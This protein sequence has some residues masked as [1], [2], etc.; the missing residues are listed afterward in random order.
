MSP[1]GQACRPKSERVPFLFGGAQRRPLRSAR[2]PTNAAESWQFPADCRFG[3]S[4]R[5][6][7]RSTAMVNQFYI[8]CVDHDF[9]P[10]F[11]KFSSYFP[12]T[13][14]LCIT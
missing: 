7:V 4:I 13:A 12:Y 6:L 1:S 5:L 9:G 11:L 14:K 3:R 10:F 8:Y 2:D